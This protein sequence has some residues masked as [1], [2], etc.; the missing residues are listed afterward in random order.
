MTGIAPPDRDRPTFLLRLRPEPGV[1]PVHALRA[2]L[3]LLL[4]KCR[5][6]CLAVTEEREEGAG[7]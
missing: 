2:A 6:R 7:R 3:K 4:R 5:M 1:D